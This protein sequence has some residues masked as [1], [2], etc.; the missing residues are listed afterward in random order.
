MA[1]ACAML[2]EAAEAYRRRIGNGWVGDGRMDE[3]V[4]VKEN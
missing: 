3:V 4:E 2:I 1:P